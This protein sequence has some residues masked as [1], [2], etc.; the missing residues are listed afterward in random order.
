M[1]SESEL[2]CL[3]PQGKKIDSIPLPGRNP[4][5]LVFGGPDRRTAFVTVNH[6][7]DGRLFTVRMP[8]PGQ[9]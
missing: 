3:S 7:R 6:D 5:N 4:T 8:A 2:W 9:P 1:Y